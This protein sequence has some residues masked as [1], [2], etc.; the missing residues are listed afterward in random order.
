MASIAKFQ[1]NVDKYNSIQNLKSNGSLVET[2]QEVRKEY[3]LFIIWF[4]IA[5]IV[6]IVTVLTLITQNEINS[7]VWIVVV[8][9]ILYC[10]YFIFKNV[11]YIL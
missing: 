4:I 8:L 9:F 6:I 5:I 2:T 3:Y 1:E 10:S 11:Y 7:A